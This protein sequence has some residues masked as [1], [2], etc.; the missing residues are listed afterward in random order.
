[1]SGYKIT[2]GDWIA[3]Q[4]QDT[5][6]VLQDAFKKA[7]TLE[8]GL[9]LAEDVYLGRPPQ[10]KQVSTDAQKQYNHEGCDRCVHQ[11]HI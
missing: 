8:A 2:I 4:V 6:I 10:V 11:V 5:Q 9:Q 1:M 3:T 7:L